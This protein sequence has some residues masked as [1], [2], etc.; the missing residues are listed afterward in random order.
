MKDMRWILLVL[1]LTPCWADIQYI[2]TLNTSPLVGHTAGPFAMN[3][4]L[5]DGSG[6]GDANNTALLSGFVFGGG[7]GAG[8]ASTV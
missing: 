4:Q 2:V 8:S 7:G 6:L 1:M 3:F 5:N